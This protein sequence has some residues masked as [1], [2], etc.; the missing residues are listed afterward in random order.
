MGKARQC[1]SCGYRKMVWEENRTETVSYGGES[2][3]LT[4]MAGWFC[5][6]CHDGMF[7]DA[8]SERHAAAGDA[9]VSRAREKS[10]EEICRIRKKLGLTQKEAA[11]LFGGGVNAFSRYERG[12]VE[13]NTAMRHL[14]RLLDA[15]PDLLEEIR[16]K[17]A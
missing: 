13:P 6:E 10:R 15:H 12:E 16:S 8:S 14:L 3:T 11:A 4:G 2:I 7:D 9:Q 17:A 5:P 1:P